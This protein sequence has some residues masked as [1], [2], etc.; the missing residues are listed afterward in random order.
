M[1]KPREYTALNTFGRS[2]GPCVYFARIARA[3]EAPLLKIGVTRKLAPR[4]Q[5]LAYFERADVELLGVI[6]GATYDDEQALLKRFRPHLVQG[7]E[8]FRDVPEIRELIA[9]LP[10][11]HRPVGLLYPSRGRR[12]GHPGAEVAN[13]CEH[14]ALAVRKYETAEATR[15]ARV[16]GRAELIEQWRRQSPA[17]AALH[18]A[19]STPSLGAF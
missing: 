9:S 5:L 12:H 8:F 14:C 11:E 10:V 18:A 2:I 1:K 6:P 3:G 15:N 16:L 4:F 17:L 7:L 19:R 13:G